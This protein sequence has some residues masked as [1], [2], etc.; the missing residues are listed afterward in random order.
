L[1]RTSQITTLVKHAAHDAG[2][3]LAGIA[4]VRDFAELK[5]FPEWIAAG[6]ACEMKLDS[7]SALRFG[8]L[9]RGRGA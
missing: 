5:H 4:P 8:R 1:N 7:S 9:R 3:E 6:H 2:F